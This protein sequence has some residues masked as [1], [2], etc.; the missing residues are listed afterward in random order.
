ML[1]VH[2]GYLHSTAGRKARAPGRHTRIPV[3]PRWHPA[4]GALCARCAGRR[5]TML[6]FRNR[7]GG[8]KLLSNAVRPLLEQA[9]ELTGQHAQ[10]E[11]LIREAEVLVNQQEE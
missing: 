9:P 10:L 6:Q 1:G 11:G 5:R 7:F 3:T 4:T 2:R 8:W